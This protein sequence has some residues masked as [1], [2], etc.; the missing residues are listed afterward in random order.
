[1][2]RA[3]A[4]E[5]GPQQQEAV[6]APA[7]LSPSQRDGSQRGGLHQD[8]PGQPGG[9]RYAS[10]LL[11][12]Y[13]VTFYVCLFL[14]SSNFSLAETM[15]FSGMSLIKLRKEEMESQVREDDSPASSGFPTLYGKSC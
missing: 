12:A 6:G 2:C 1:M 13:S 9:E 3:P 8:G 5:G 10:L 4:G 15:D 7:G 11:P 14:Y